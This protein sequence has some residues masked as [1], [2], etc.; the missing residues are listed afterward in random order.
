MKQLVAVANNPALMALLTKAQEHAQQ[1]HTSKL[2]VDATRDELAK[3]SQALLTEMRKIETAV[4]D[5]KLLSLL[6][7][8]NDPKFKK[9]VDDITLAGHN[10]Q[11]VLSNPTATTQ[12]L[13]AQFAVCIA[14]MQ[15]FKEHMT[16]FEQTARQYLADTSKSLQAQADRSQARIDASLATSAT[17]DSRISTNTRAIT[18][19]RGITK[20]NTDRLD[21]HWKLIVKTQ[22]ELAQQESVWNEHT[23]AI[24]SLNKQN[25]AQEKQIGRVE[26][27]V[28][29]VNARI[30]PLE[31]EFRHRSE[32][33][34]GNA[35]MLER[36]EGTEQ[37]VSKL[38]PKPAAPA[39]PVPSAPPGGPAVEGSTQVEGA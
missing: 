15:Q 5:P 27:G 14:N 8:I 11:T 21:E 31:R 2:A 12:N 33:D 32:G 38:Q 23:R 7:T 10:L 26:N 4:H 16:A 13:L 6:Q 30:R 34:R 9:V 20:Q 35:T 19:L 39:M 18:E 22:N 37:A 3:T 25:A 29:S 17:Y 24:A 28:T 1:V 36:V